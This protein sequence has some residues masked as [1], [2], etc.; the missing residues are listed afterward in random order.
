MI[1]KSNRYDEELDL[2]VLRYK[3]LHAGVEI[4]NCFYILHEREG[5]VVT[6]YGKIA[7][8]TPNETVVATYDHTFLLTNAQVLDAA[9][10]AIHASVYAWESSEWEEDLKTS[11]ENPDATYYPTPNRKLLDINGNYQYI[12]IY[13]ITVLA[14]EPYSHKQ[15]IIDGRNGDLLGVFDVGEACFGGDIHASEHLCNENPECEEVD[16]IDNAA[17]TQINCHTGIVLIP[18]MP[19]VSQDINTYYRGFPNY[20][21]ILKDECRA[22]PGSNTWA[23]HTRSD[24]KFSPNGGKFSD[25]NNDWGT[26]MRAQA[27]WA[28][29]KS[30]D[31]FKDKFSWSGTDGNAKKLEVYPALQNVTGN[32]LNIQQSP[33]LFTGQLTSPDRLQVV[34]GQQSLE[35]IGHE[36][37]HGV[38][39]NHFFSSA[40]LLNPMENRAVKEGYSDIFSQLIEFHTS[41]IPN[42]IVSGTAPAT[43]LTPSFNFSRN[44]ANPSLSIPAQPSNRFGANWSITDG[45]INCGVI[46]HWFY[47]LTFGGGNVQGLGITKTEKIIYKSLDIIVDN[48]TFLDMRTA[49]IQAA[50]LLY[51]ACFNEVV[52]TTNAWA[53]RNVGVSYNQPPCISL[54]AF[55]GG[56]VHCNNSTITLTAGNNLQGSLSYTWTATGSTS[57]TGQGTPTASFTNLAIPSTI[58][59]C[60]VSNGTTTLSASYTFSTK[61]C[62]FANPNNIEEDVYQ[63]YPNP[64]D[65]YIDVLTPNDCENAQVDIYDML[66]KILSTHTISKS[67]NRILISALPQGCYKLLITSG[68]D[69]HTITLIK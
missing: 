14:I 9:K 41:F 22:A 11:T 60:T 47:T 61:S 51:G 52:Q 10:L 25:A 20:D 65:E 13:E 59:A 8:D 18:G 12:P 21:F 44:F 57:I 53:N 28:A 64:A 43:S 4:E 37:T 15:V 58:I 32:T 42:W 34:S 29:E 63:I 1:L 3:Q 68:Q 31:Y 27:H 33:A 54:G 38:A 16:K 35:I 6:A 49:T 55:K 50:I 66:G 7:G 40:T 69:T 48:P 17:Q 5:R 23:I 30:W 36:Y 19:I 62:R 46:N 26:E 56:F 24:S 2:S 39:N 45:H 67:E